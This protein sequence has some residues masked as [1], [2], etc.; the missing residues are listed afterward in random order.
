M[1]N[2]AP[3]R[4]Y[5]AEEIRT[6]TSMWKTNTLVDIAKKINRSEQSVTYISNQIRKA[7]YDLPK[8]HS[9]NLRDMIRE[10]LNIK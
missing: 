6:V 1:S 10:T 7:G 8:K 2:R 5:T 4:G 3:W 9:A